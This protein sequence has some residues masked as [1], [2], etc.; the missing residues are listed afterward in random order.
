MYTP[1]IIVL[2]YSF[3]IQFSIQQ[4]IVL[5]DYY[6]HLYAWNQTSFSFDAKYLSLPP[7]APSL[8]PN[9]FTSP[10]SEP[11]HSYSDPASQQDVVILDLLGDLSHGYYIDLAANDARVKSNT[12]ILDVYNMWNGVCI[13]PNPKHFFGL[14][15]YR[16][17]KI[18]INPVAGIPGESVRFRF[19]LDGLGG[20]VHNETD[21]Q[22]ED[23]E[24]TIVITTT[25]NHI[26]H[27]SQSPKLIHYLSLDIEGAEFIAMEH[28]DFS[29][30]IFY[31]ISV[32]RPKQKLHELFVRHGYVFL[33]VLLGGYG[34][35]L[36]L[37]HTFPKLNEQMKLHYRAEIVPVWNNNKHP[38]L[39]HPPWNG[40]YVPVPTASKDE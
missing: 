33:R 17:C 19:H 29:K 36:Y 14:L 4:P 39:L 11:F 27:F 38:Y 26:L 37:H 5:L 1:F 7:T 16:K 32:E 15:S 21:N 10:S 2:I 3:L 28:F 8:Q 35:C 30:H 34:E 24:D 18:F 9:F 31:V 23:P 22:G 20:I 6:P 12:Y 13:E 40:S 25:L